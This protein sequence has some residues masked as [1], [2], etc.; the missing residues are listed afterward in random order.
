MHCSVLRPDAFDDGAKQVRFLYKLVEQTFPLDQ[1]SWAIEFGNLSVIE[2]HNTVRIKNGVD[3]MSNGD[4]GSVLEHV[5][6]QCHLEHGVRFNV[7][8]GL[9]DKCQ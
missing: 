8:G 5:A 1:L 4:D 3:A 7:N 2:Y 6:A 9:D